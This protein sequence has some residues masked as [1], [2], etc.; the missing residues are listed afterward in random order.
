MIA[1]VNVAL[2]EQTFSGSLS[3]GMHHASYAQGDGFCSVNGLVVATMYAQEKYGVNVTILDLDAHAGGGTDA[4]LRHHN[5]LNVQ[6]LDVTVS[7]FNTYRGTRNNLDLN[8]TL[9]D[10]SD[11]TYLASVRMILGQIPTGDDRLLIYNAGMDPYPTVSREA[12]LERER[13]V[14]GFAGEQRIPTVFGLAG[15]YTWS[16]SAD[17]V[18]AMHVATVAQFAEE[19][20]LQEQDGTTSTT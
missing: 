11:H 8:L 13:L 10:A 14:A 15:G 1:A 20:P 12:L 2:V 18:A 5:M 16:Q 19:L 3:S 6:H 9:S 17:D 7:P 4:L